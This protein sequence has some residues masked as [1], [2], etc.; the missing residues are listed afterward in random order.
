MAALLSTTTAVAQ[1][2]Q[3]VS[4]G[5]GVAENPQQNNNRVARDAAS[6][7]TFANQVN[8]TAQ[9]SRHRQDRARA[10][11]A[12]ELTAGSVVND[13]AGQKIATIEGI[14]PDGVILANEAGRVKVPLE[15]FGLNKSG[16]LLD[17]TKSQFDALVAQANGP[18]K[19]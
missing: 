6:D 9:A 8:K 16:L 13:S 18:A 1:D 15:A 7:A 17:V 11:K 12:E 2:G 3:P 14:E 10:A 5:Q 4:T 19:S